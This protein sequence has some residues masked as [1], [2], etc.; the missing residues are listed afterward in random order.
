MPSPTLN[1]LQRQFNNA[2]AR[3]R[4]LMGEIWT[5][6]PNPWSFRPNQHP[7]FGAYMNAYKTAQNLQRRIAQKR[8]ENEQ[9]RIANEQARRHR[10]RH[11]E[12][13]YYRK[14]FNIAARPPT[15]GG[16]LYRRIAKK[17]A[18]T[19]SVGTSMSP[20]RRS[21]KRRRTSP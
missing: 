8:R 21:P 12:K 2:S 20:N 7:K 17:Y 5:Y 4:R 16:T 1:N 10:Q 15:E 14:W 11:L 19:R 6:G 18:K 3:E 9:R 13:K